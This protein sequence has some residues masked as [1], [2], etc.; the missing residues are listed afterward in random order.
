MLS[1]LIPTYNA[2]CTRLVEEIHREATLLGIKFEIL[3]ADDGSD[4]EVNEANR[5]I[6][7]LGNCRFIPSTENIGPARIRN[8]LA[9]Q[10]GYQY[11]LFLDAD[12]MPVRATFLADYLRDALP[13]GVVCGG[14]CYHRTLP[15]PGYALRYNYGIRVEEKTPEERSRHPYERFISMSFLADRNVF[16]KVRFDDEMHFGYEDTYF[17]S[18][19]EQNDVPILHI[20]NPVYHLSQ[21]SSLD[22]LRKIR[23]S[24]VN[25]SHGIEKQRHHVRLL[26]WYTFLERCGM[27]LLVAKVFQTALPAIEKNLTG[28][29]PSLKL[30]AFYKLGYLCQILGSK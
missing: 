25:L 17:G 23:T 30:F 2:I 8:K 13:G 4:K 16:G 7:H 28:E 19:L 18:L 22:Y 27:T 6:E 26:R 24:I 29:H 21:E 9:D 11:L 3:V 14:L 12:V 20:D 5:S 1:V 15:Q 10:A